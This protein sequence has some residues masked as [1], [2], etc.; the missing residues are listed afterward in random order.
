MRHSEKSPIGTSTNIQQTVA[1]VP[2]VSELVSIRSPSP[3]VKIFSIKPHAFSSTTTSLET[4]AIFDDFIDISGYGSVILNLTHI[5]DIDP[6]FLDQ[7]RDDIQRL[8]ER[9][10]QKL[11][12]SGA[13]G[14]VLAKVLEFCRSVDP[15]P[16]VGL[17]RERDQH[18]LSQVFV[19]H[20]PD[21]ARRM[22]RRE[23]IIFE[24]IENKWCRRH[25]VSEIAY[26]SAMFP[27]K[28]RDISK[29]NAT[30]K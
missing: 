14:K 10:Q 12:I 15:T 27:S 21:S 1:V 29:S 25:G 8:H 16:K 22:Q 7:L 30:R 20:T 2:R 19:N 4:T 9:N 18:V 26:H 6:K 3:D 13:K 28:K 17:N 11:I 23:K 5:G 24:T